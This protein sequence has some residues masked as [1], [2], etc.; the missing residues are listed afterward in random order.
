MTLTTVLSV[1]LIVA[2]FLFV[3]IVITAG[4]D[5]DDDIDGGEK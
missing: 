3:N 5:G 1:F 2:V 4:S